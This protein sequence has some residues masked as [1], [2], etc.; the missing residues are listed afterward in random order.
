M[1]MLSVFLLTIYNEKKTIWL[2]E[3]AAILQFT[4]IVSLTSIFYEKY[5]P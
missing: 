3:S 1:Q 4:L 5:N 2:T